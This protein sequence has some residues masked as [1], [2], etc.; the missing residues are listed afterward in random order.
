MYFR[1][2]FL[3]MYINSIV[4]WPGKPLGESNKRMYVCNYVCMYVCTYVRTCVRMY[5]CMYVCMYDDVTS[6]QFPNTRT[7]YLGGAVNK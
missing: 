3:Y 6:H 2:C 1:L 5:V 7:S 4:N